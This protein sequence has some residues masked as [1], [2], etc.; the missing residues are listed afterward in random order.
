LKI[1][2]T[3]DQGFIGSRAV[4]YFSRQHDIVT[5][6]WG[7]SLPDLSQGLD[8]VM[9]FGA[10]SSTQERDVE[11]V[12]RHN[13]DFSAWLIQ[14]CDTHRVNIQYSSSASVYGLGTEFK[15]DSPVDPRTPYAWSKYLFERY[16]RSRE[17]NIIHQGFRYFNVYGPGEINKGAQAS[18]YTQ[19]ERQAREQGRIEIF[20]QPVPAR[21]DFVPVQRV[22]DVHGKML[23]I[24]ESG[25]YN[26]GSGTTT[27]FKEI[28]DEIAKRYNV[29]VVEIPMPTAFQGAYQNYTCADITKLKATLN[30]QDNS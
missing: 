5:Y 18:P 29:P 28:A 22:I 20:E 3:G 12:L 25:V 14:Q 11:R 1:L 7:D 9:H 27:S 21:R 4:E 24:A 17:W 15:E 19:F 16:V 8:W 13:L 23:D 26:I 2:I 6:N 10:I 30:E